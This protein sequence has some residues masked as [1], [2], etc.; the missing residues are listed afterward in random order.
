MLADVVVDS[1]WESILSFLPDEWEKMARKLGAFTRARAFS[2]PE[3]LLRTLLLHLAA[4]CSL[5]ETALRARRAGLSTASDVAIMKR[6]RSS[7]HWLRYLAESLRPSDS[8][9]AIS[10][11]NIPFRLCAVD[12]TV[13]SEPGSTGSDWRLHYSLEL[14]SL[15]CTYFVLTDQHT[16][17]TLSNFPVQA[18]DLII[19]DRAY[20]K[21]PGIRHVLRKNGHALIRMRAAN[22]SLMTEVGVRFD[23]LHEAKALHEHQ[24]NSWNVAMKAKRGES[25]SGR[26]CV[27]RR[28]AESVE[29]AQ[30]K[31]RRMASKKQQT[32]TKNALEAAKYVVLFTTANR[33]DLSLHAAFEVY[34]YRWQIELAFK[35]L[36]SLTG[37]GH[38]PKYDD[39]SCRAWLYGK[40]FIGLLAEAMA[41]SAFSP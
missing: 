6:L 24:M 13:V 41:R 28:D 15:S 26:V 40:L 21:V 9:D 1:D 27:Y 25:V 8:L 30:R 12:A 16:G 23:L 35:R 10:Q 14:M 2:T 17:E 3:T 19:G 38:L 5:R 29:I 39:E 11:H 20:D 36:K 32:L 4:G 18:G 31:V 37:F 22:A 34:R 33:A 7:E